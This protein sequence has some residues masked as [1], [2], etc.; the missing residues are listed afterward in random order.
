[1]FKQY[2]TGSSSKTGA[3]YIQV[4]IKKHPLF[5]GLRFVY[6]HRLMMAEYLDRKLRRNEAVHHR[7]GNRTDNRIKNLELMSTKKHAQIHAL[8]AV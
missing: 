6:E 2:R 7:N 4:S 3:G 1:M 8:E 5:P